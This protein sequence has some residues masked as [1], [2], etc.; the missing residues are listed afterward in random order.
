MLQP[1]APHTIHGDFELI[2]RYVAATFARYEQVL[3]ATIPTFDEPRIS[4]PDLAL[5]RLR[6]LVETLAGFAVGATV[7]AVAREA[8]RGFTLELHGRIDQLLGRITR[9]GSLAVATTELV[10]PLRFLSDSKRP[11]LDALGS[12][13]LARLTQSIP[14]TRT[15]V[16]SIHAEIMRTVPSRLPQLAS[17]LERLAADSALADAF[18]GQLASGWQCYLASVSER[19]PAAPSVAEKRE[20]DEEPWRAWARRIEG[21]PAPTV[22]TRDQILTEGFLQQIA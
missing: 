15:H 21:P 17:V 2:E 19:R 3:V 20:R 18:S 11:L 4:E 9:E 5:K 10:P 1:G 14:E 7:G 12:Q 22:P 6:Y 16:S 8:R 13:L